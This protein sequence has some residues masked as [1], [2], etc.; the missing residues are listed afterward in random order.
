[1]LVDLHIHTYFSDGTMSPEEVAY[2]AKKKGLKIIAVTDHNN[3]Q[4]YDRLKNACDEY[5]I[6]AVRGV[7]ID[8]KYKDKVLH[9]LAYDFKDN[10]KLINIIDKSREYLLQ[11]SIDLIDKMSKDYDNISNEDYEKYQY[12]NTK[13]AWKGAH[14]LLERGFSDSLIDGLKYYKEYGCDYI[15]YD[16]ATVKEV[17]HA[18]HEAGGYAVLAHPSNYYSNLSKEELIE[19]LDDLKN[20]GIDGVECYYPSNGEELTKTCVE[21]CKENDM[22]ITAG[23]DGHGEF[24]K[25]I[26]NI[27]YY[28]GAVR[29]TVD[30]LNLKFINLK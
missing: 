2:D 1:M 5:G 26:K 12:D 16:F 20:E 28:I 25:T 3:T 6:I 10:K 14:Y 9:V 29:A 17:S 23:S 11:T 19:V 13:G 21:F 24:T 30:K 22:I 18:I 7:E 8:C 4:A 15:E 27:D